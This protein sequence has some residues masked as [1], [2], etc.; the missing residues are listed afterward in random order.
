EITQVRVAPRG[1]DAS[2]AGRAATASVAVPTEAE[3]VPVGRLHA[4]ARMEALVDEAVP[5]AEQQLLDQH[6]LAEIGIP[7]AHGGS[8]SIGRL[9][10]IIALAPRP[11]Q[12]RRPVRKRR[13]GI[14]AAESEA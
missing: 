6:R 14:R 8:F 12:G 1:R 7:A 5:G 3:A 2:I 9:E 4:H 10:S 11:A 13:V